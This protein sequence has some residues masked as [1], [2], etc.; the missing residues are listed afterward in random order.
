MPCSALKITYLAN[1]RVKLLRLLKTVSRKGTCVRGDRPLDKVPTGEGEG[2]KATGA[3]LRAQCFI[4]LVLF[5][6]AD[7]LFRRAEGF[8]PK[9]NM[10]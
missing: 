7:F 8:T 10:I 6:K 2:Y 1:A 5:H 9:F 3:I 4:L